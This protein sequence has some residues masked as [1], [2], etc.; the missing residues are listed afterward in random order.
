MTAARNLY[1]TLD[2][3]TLA[4]LQWRAKWLK[5]ARPKQI[6]PPGNWRTWLALA[7]RGFGK[8]RLGAEDCGWYAAKN[9]NVRVGVAAPTAGDTRDICFEGESGLNSVIPQ[10]LIADYNRSPP[11]QLF[12]KNGSTIKG[13]SASD[14]DRFRGPQHHRFWCE[15]MASWPFPQQAWDMIQFG[16]RLGE[17]PQAIVTTTPKPKKFLRDLRADP[18]TKVTVGSTHENKANLPQKFFDEIIK[19]E[20]TQLGKQEIYAVILDPE[21]A[22]II[23]RSWFKLWPNKLVLPRFELVIASF[24]TAFTDKTVNDPTA[25]TIWGVFQPIKTDVYGKPVNDGP[26]SAILCDAWDEHLEYPELKAKAKAVAEARYGEPARRPEVILIEDKGSGISLRQDLHAMN[27]PAVP[28]NPGKADKAQRA[29]TISYLVK[30]GLFWLPESARRAGKPRDWCDGFLE[31]VC[32]FTGEEDKE[33]HDDYLDTFT[34]TAA[35]LRDTQW[36]R[37][38]TT[39]VAR[40]DDDVDEEP[41]DIHSPYGS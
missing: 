21:D 17:N 34:Q 1:D 13:Y 35:Y 25:C 2:V 3:P 5:E 31:Q 39:M 12:L 7:G 19:Y 16:L 23:K 41:A 33:A 36:L 8:T 6:T 40:H 9:P 22:G 26:M 38:D 28:Y 15:E 4:M 37:D 10:E 24:D 20:G 11:G 29:H 32:G 18:G 27:L 14:P 30:N